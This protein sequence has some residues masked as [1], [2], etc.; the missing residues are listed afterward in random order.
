MLGAED[1]SSSEANP[2]HEFRTSATQEGRR[3]LETSDRPAVP[4]TLPHCYV[5]VIPKTELKL[6]AGNSPNCLAFWRQTNG[7]N[8]AASKLHK[9]AQDRLSQH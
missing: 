5:E 8:A 1:E 4:V 2:Y 9:G 3:H 6:P 7:Y